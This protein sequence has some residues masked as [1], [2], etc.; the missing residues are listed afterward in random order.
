MLFINCY[1]LRSCGGWVLTTQQ[2]SWITVNST[3]RLQFVRLGSVLSDVVVSDT[4][5]VQGI[6]LSPSLVTLYTTDFKY[7][8]LTF[9][10]TLLLSVLQLRC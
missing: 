6:V 9:L 8:F 4:G 1:W 5:A 2:F 7:N 10:M 3:G